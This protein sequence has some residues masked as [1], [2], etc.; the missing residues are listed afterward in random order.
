MDPAEFVFCFVLVIFLIG[1]VQWK[2]SGDKKIFRFTETP[3]R[4]RNDM[5]FLGLVGDRTSAA[6]INNQA[7]ETDTNTLF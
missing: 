7:H 6:N 5:T 4:I 1:F 3:K 2:K